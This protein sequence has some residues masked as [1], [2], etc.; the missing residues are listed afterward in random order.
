MKVIVVPV[1]LAFCPF[2]SLA[3]GIPLS[4]SIVWTCPSLLISATSHEERAFTQETPT[5]CNPPE[6]LYA[7]FSNLPPA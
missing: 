4:N 3:F 2:L 5:P 7:L 1:V 6:T